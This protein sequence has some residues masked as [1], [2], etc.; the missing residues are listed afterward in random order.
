MYDDLWL[1]LGYEPPDL[2]VVRQVEDMDEGVVVSGSLPVTYLSRR[3]TSCP[4]SLGT[5]CDPMKPV[6][7]VTSA[8][9]ALSI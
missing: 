7:P 8:L 3:W 6:E 4:F 9:K 5:R 1:Q 2:G